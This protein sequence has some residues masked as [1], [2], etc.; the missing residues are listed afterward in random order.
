MKRVLL[1]LVVLLL[2][3]GIY[4]VDISGSTAAAGIQGDGSQ[5]IYLDQ[6]AVLVVGPVEFDGLIGYDI[7]MELDDN[8][9]E[10]ELAAK[11]AISNFVF[12]T[13]IYGEKDLELR[14]NKSWIDFAYEDFGFNVTTCT[15]L[16]P[17]QEDWQGAEFSVSYKPEP[18]EFTVGYLLTDCAAEIAEVAPGEP[19]NGGVYAKV[20]VSY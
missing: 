1:F 10:Y 5:K 18:F 20:K 11:Y 13:K 6:T 9:W 16:D 2:A 19:E 14:K 17:E 3:V 8:F 15:L 4:A 7:D 12:G